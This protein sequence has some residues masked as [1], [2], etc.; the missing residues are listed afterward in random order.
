MLNF[1]EFPLNFSS[2][3][4]IFP[5]WDADF[6]FVFPPAPR[7][8]MFCRGARLGRLPPE[9]GCVE[10]ASDADSGGG[11]GAAG[12]FSSRWDIFVEATRES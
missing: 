12:G 11:L 7:M 4:T 10:V 2:K 3:P 1:I 9:A 5:P 8:S 6:F